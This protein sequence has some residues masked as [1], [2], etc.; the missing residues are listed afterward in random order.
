MITEAQEKDLY[1]QLVADDHQRDRAKFVYTFDV[2]EKGT[3]GQYIVWP[4]SNETARKIIEGLDYNN[5][6]FDLDNEIAKGGQFGTQRER[7][8]QNQGGEVLCET[9]EMRRCLQAECPL[10]F[11]KEGLCREF[12]MVSR[13]AVTD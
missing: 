4:E 3:L 12:K 13:R 11:A 1:S 2:L 7:I 9:L 8:K 10:Y 6:P 5:I